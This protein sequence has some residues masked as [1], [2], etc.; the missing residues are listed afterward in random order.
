MTYSPVDFDMNSQ[1]EIARGLLAIADELRR[2][3]DIAL[4]NSIYA[5]KDWTADEKL[6]TYESLQK[7]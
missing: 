7:L 3:N 6:S 2:A 1:Y 5:D 4:V